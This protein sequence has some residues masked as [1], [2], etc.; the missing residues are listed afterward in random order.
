MA[1]HFASVVDSS[2]SRERKSAIKLVGKEKMNGA[3]RGR[4][5]RGGGV[6]GLL[7]GEIVVGMEGWGAGWGVWA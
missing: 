4:E 3:E 5:W 2:E 6:G 1:N 7:M